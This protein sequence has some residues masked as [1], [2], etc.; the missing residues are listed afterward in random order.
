MKLQVIGLLEL[1]WR[2]HG[3]NWLPR[4]FHHGRALRCGKYKKKKQKHTK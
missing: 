4:P 1:I 2:E 3:I